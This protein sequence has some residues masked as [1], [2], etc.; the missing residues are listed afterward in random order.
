MERRLVSI[1]Q[2]TEGPLADV[3]LVFLRS[4]E[5][6]VDW[7][8]AD[9]RPHIYRIRVKAV[10]AAAG[11]DVYEPA[12]SIEAGLASALRGVNWPHLIQVEIS[13]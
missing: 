12:N 2:I 5:I 1:T 9:G 11:G 6:A 4:A 8:L 3:P 10:G 13:A 7:A